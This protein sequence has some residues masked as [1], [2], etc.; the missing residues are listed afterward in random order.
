VEDVIEPKEFGRLDFVVNVGLIKIFRCP[1]ETSADLQSVKIVKC[2]LILAERVSVMNVET[3]I[4]SK[5][6]M[7][8]L[9]FAINVRKTH[10]KS[11]LA[12][13]GVSQIWLDNVFIATMLTV[14]FV[15]TLMTTV[16]IVL[17]TS[18]N[19]FKSIH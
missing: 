2:I 11:A 10:L 19:G 3:Y 7:K 6:V 17:R 5:K 16:M 14:M 13:K 12:V 1:M 15:I 4:V 9:R 8:Q 18:Q